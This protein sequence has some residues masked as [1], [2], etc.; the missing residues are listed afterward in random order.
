M[1]TD[2]IVISNLPQACVLDR[3]EFENIHPFGKCKLGLGAACADTAERIKRSPYHRWQEGHKKSIDKFAD[4]ITEL[5]YQALA[6]QYI[7]T[8]V[9]ACET[10]RWGEDNK[11]D[12]NS[13]HNLDDLLTNPDKLSGINGD[14]LYDYL[15]ENGYDVQP[16]SRDSFKGI[17][18]EEGGGYFKI[19]SGETGTIRI[20]LDGIIIE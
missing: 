6:L 8:C 19:S 17:P 7:M 9:P 18:F 20:D 15:I 2:C 11:G 4:G 1:N 16:L 13:I 12:L 10:T 5:A 14:E 3:K